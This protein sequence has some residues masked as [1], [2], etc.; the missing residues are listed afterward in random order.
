[1]VAGHLRLKRGY[2]HM[3]LSYNNEAGKRVTKSVTT[4]LKEKGNKKRA[5]KML[6]EL[7]RQATEEQQAQRQAAG[8]YFDTYLE[9]W[10][11]QMQLTVSPT[12]FRTCSTII[13]GSICPYFKPLDLLISEL[14]PK[15]IAEY[16]DSLLGHG[17]SPSTV[18]RY[19]TNIHK[20]AVVDGLIQKNPADCVEPPKQAKYTAAHYSADEC[21][22]LLAAVKGPELELPVVLTLFLGLRRC[23][24][25]G[26][27]WEA[28]DFAQH[29][30]HIRHA[31]HQVQGQVIERD[32]LKRKSS[33]RT[34]PLSHEIEQLLLVQQKADGFIC[35]NADGQ[36]LTLV[37]MLHDGQ[38]E[39][40][41]T[42]STA[43]F[44]E[45][46][47][48]GMIR[49]YR[50]REKQGG[51]TA[52][53]VFLHELGHLLYMRET[54]TI[55]D[56]PESFPRFLRSM[57]ADA[58]KLSSA[59]LLELF[60]DSFLIAVSSQIKD[61]GDPFPEIKQNVKRLCFSYMEHFISELI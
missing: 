41:N 42:E 20:R 54:K 21:R 29:V 56:V 47:M 24:V 6:L 58:E 16:Y 12:T 18:R 14:K 34:L 11:K 27:K 35:L 3:I 33:C 15:H 60:T 53:H 49:I 22:E 57:G 59:Q 31:V 17:L 30:I 7:R 28:V 51:F 45:S 44:D 52:T 13:H 36:L 40:C 43:T 19:H 4:H 46:G 50:M 26:M 48:Q 23:E 39:D 10:L 32:T 5:E 2:W 61:F 38:A 25:L 55:K 8:I 1:M 9:T 37:V